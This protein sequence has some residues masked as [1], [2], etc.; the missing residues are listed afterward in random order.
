[1]RRKILASL[2]G[3]CV[4]MGGAFVALA[5]SPQGPES[6]P[7]D[8]DCSEPFVVGDRMAVTC[9]SPESVTT[10]TQPT[11]TTTTEPTTTTTQPTTTTTQPTTTTTTS[12]PGG[13]LV[14]P[15]TQEQT[16]PGFRDN[17]SFKFGLACTD[18]NDD[19]R[20]PEN[21]EVI[22]D[23]NAKGKK[24]LA[25]FDYLAHGM[26]YLYSESQPG[27]HDHAWWEDGDREGYKCVYGFMY[28]KHP[29]PFGIFGNN[30]RE[31]KFIAQ[32]VVARPS[33]AGYGKVNDTYM[34]EAERYFDGTPTPYFGTNA[35]EIPEEDCIIEAHELVEFDYAS[36][37]PHGPDDIRVGLFR[38]DGE[39]ADI[40]DFTT[41]DVELGP[42]GE[43][44]GWFEFVS[45]EDGLVH[46]VFVYEPTMQVSHGIYY[47]T[48]NDGRIAVEVNGVTLQDN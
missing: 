35:K 4:V 27:N 7:A 44:M 17:E 16:I 32:A 14:I 25:D 40:R 15:A 37:V 13:D 34:E 36:Y 18:A 43:P 24:F 6:I 47:R 8:W 11:T 20:T 45:I 19:P 5:G 30:P 28:E 42:D 3:L 10:T 9:V 31:G 23:L 2:T 38:S 46:L 48:M 29:N 41:V 26:P 12:P 21:E 1:M 33:G 22:C 39:I